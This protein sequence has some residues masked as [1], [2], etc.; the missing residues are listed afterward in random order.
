MDPDPSFH[1]DPET[2]DPLSIK[3]MRICNHRHTDTARGS[4]LSVCAFIVSVHGPQSLHFQP[5]KLLDFTLM[6]FRIRLLSLMWIQIR[7]STLM[8]SRRRIRI[9]VSEMMR[10]RIRFTGKTCSSFLI[11]VPCPTPHFSKQNQLMCSPPHA[12][13]GR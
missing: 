3:V 12:W 9:G 5:Q 2:P 10:I 11:H 13:A 7:L 4:I 6:R 8:R 1:F